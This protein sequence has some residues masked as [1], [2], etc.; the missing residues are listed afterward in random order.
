M[1]HVL[2]TLFIFPLEQ[3][4]ELF[5]LFVLR[6][7]L[8]PALSVLGVSVAVSLVTLPLYFMA[9]RVQNAERDI[10][11]KM[12]PEV[13][14]IKAAFSGDERF[15]RLSTY[16]RQNGY[17]PLYSLRSSVSLLIQVPFFIAAFHFLSNLEMI[18]YIPFGPIAALGSPD[19]LFTVNGFTIN[20]LPVLM[21]VINCVSAAVYTRGLPARD[22]TQLYALAALFLLLLYNSPAGMV[23]YWTG[24]NLFSLAKNVLQK[25][26]HSKRIVFAGVSAFCFFAIVFIMFFHG[27]AFAKR[28]AVSFALFAVPLLPFLFKFFVKIKPGFLA[29][30]SEPKY[31]A[32]VFAL[33]L[34]VLFLLGAL[35]IPSSLIASSVQQFSFISGNVKNPF[36]FIAVA[37]LQ[38]LGVFILYPLCLYRMLPQKAKVAVSALTLV[39][40]GIAAVNVFL[41]P[42]SYGYLT[43]MFG[44]SG[45]GPSPSS[46]EILLNMAAIAL[47]AAALLFLFFRFGK[48]LTP[49]LTITAF[50]FAL[51]SAVNLT[52][53]NGEFQAFRSR[54]D[55]GDFYGVEPIFRFSQTGQNVVVIMLDRGFGPFVPYIFQER[56]QLLNSFDGFVWHRNTISFSSG[57]IFGAPGLFG[58]YEYTPL[59]MDARD[60]V[61]LVEKHNEALLLLPKIFL[62]QGFEV[63]VTDPTFANYSWVPDLSIFDA[64]PQI[65]ARNIIGRYTDMWL[66][67]N[68]DLNLNPSR[69][70]ILIEAYLLRFSFF[71]FSPVLLRNFVYDHANWLTVVP[72]DG[73]VS[74]AFNRTTLDNYVALYMLPNL[75]VIG[76]RHF[77]AYNVLTNDLPHEPFFLTLPDYTPSNLQGHRGDGPFANE[78]H[79]HVNMASFI[80]LGKWFDF[81]RENGVYDNT[82]IIIVSDHGAHALRGEVA[83]NILPPWEVRLD[84][85]AAILMVKDFNATGSL[86]VDNTFMTNADMPLIALEGIVENPIN[87]WTG[88]PLTS[89]KENGIIIHPRSWPFGTLE[90]L[91]PRYRFN[92]N[93]QYPSL[94]VRDYIFAAENWTLVTID[95]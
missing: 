29:A 89:D 88:S 59:E 50:A 31:N 24:N 41:F 92:F 27:G 26:R 54:L 84:A 14:N 90:E 64:F 76:E 6:V 78:E 68:R 55:R 7:T 79:F 72:A 67:I 4:I 94:H 70:E 3:V 63:T 9:E 39:F 95:P 10:Q 33:S 57:T 66:E 47:C 52:R 28:L 51:L 81:L 62:E 93:H 60:N 85:Y 21:T 87:P 1:L 5:Y 19:A 82:R 25:T 15:M 35:V 44:F 20:I 58:G 49:L 65:T 46:A 61:L 13:D 37:A 75:T 80:L 71:R 22:K 74:P 69:F 48:V 8:N 91:R 11:A 77:N 12:K 86:S 32:E 38:A 30:K 53:I 42:G 83:A 43:V 18:R 2:Y 23:L 17:R 34:A 40:A 36:S 16:Y 56:P 73:Y 45:G